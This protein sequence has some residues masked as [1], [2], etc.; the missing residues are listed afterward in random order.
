[1]KKKD[2]KKVQMVPLTILIIG[3]LLM[4]SITPLNTYQNGVWTVMYTVNGDKTDFQFTTTLPSGDDKWS[5]LAFSNDNKMG[6]DNACVCKSSPVSS[7]QHYYTN[8]NSG[9]SLVDAANPSIGLT[10]IKVV[11]N[12]GMLNCS[13][14]R[15]NTMSDN[16]KYYDT[17]KSYYILT[18]TG[19][20]A[21][22]EHLNVN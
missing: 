22:S 21:T 6:E 1:V 19:N 18:A 20:D 16:S 5:A 3:I 14:T 17:K 9:I 11:Y 15:M 12:N 2:K 4:P 8:G 10:N 7:V 13:F